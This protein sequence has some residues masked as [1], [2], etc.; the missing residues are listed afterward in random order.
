MSEPSMPRTVAEAYLAHL[1]QRGVDYLFANGGTDFAPLVEAYARAPESGLT[2]PQPI[3]VAHENAAVCMA[4]GYTMVTGRPQAVMVHVSVGTA[5]AVLGLMNSM[6]DRVP[7]LMTAG[8]TPLFEEGRF[9]SRASYIHWAQEMF[10]QAGMVREFVKWDY[11]LRDGLNVEQVVDRA[12]AI[13]TAA[14]AGP[15]Y[16]SL[17]REV[18]AQSAEPRVRSLPG[19]AATP[20][21]A[22]PDPEAVVRAAALLA[23]AERPLIVTIA[24]GQ[25]PQTVSM[26]AELAERFALPVVEARARFM[27]LS[28]AHPM[29]IG[30]DAASALDEADVVLVLEADVPWMPNLERPDAQAQIIHAGIDPLFSR[31]PMRSFP[32]DLSVTA[33]MRAFLPALTR[34][35]KMASAGRDAQISARRER[36][37]AWRRAAWGRY[38]DE[39]ALDERAGGPISKVWLSRCLNDIKPPDAILV[40]EYSVQRPHIDFTQA[41]TYYQYPPIGALGW[42]VPAALGAQMAAPDRLVIATVGDG[43][44]MFAN[45]AACHQVA[46][47]QKLPV[48]TIV[49]NNSRWDAVSDAALRM[50]PQ[51]AAKQTGNAQLSSLSPSPRFEQY[52]EASGGY[53]EC[54]TERAELPHALARALR[55]VR[56]ERR[57]ALL[58]VICA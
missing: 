47:A 6:R 53:G 46:A 48:L 35:M 31:Y 9:G 13:A 55:V 37:A 32:S 36:A 34:A 22:H 14:P 58:N 12:L 50:Y 38:A 39:R 42:G 44:Y 40:N 27:C 43:A 29:H 57:Q 17:P 5:N 8:R 10:D 2:F 41:G 3:A 24:S 26:L 54:V 28:P 19:H 18:L 7:L 49:C 56:E 33:P 45:P 21:A 20:T 1:K 30:F 23:Q 11:E 15:V 25:D 16:L 52:A 51:G 4:L